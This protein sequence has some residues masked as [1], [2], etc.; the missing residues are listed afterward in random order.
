MVSPNVFITGIFLVTANANSIRSLEASS[1]SQPSKNYGNLVCP[2]KKSENQQW[3][4]C[5]AKSS[6]SQE[7]IEAFKVVAV[8]IYGHLQLGSDI[9]VLKLVDVEIN[10]NV[11]ENILAV[12]SNK[13]DEL[14]SYAAV[15]AQVK[16]YAE[17]IV[18]IQVWINILHHN[19]LINIA[20]Q[21]EIVLYV[22]ILLAFRC[23]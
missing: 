13:P 5:K 14:S 10:V 22:V 11:Y 4:E 18:D 3:S 8:D 23:W 16:L 9:N 1:G 15:L 7:C 19:S 2:N 20:L 21:L 6:Q 12:F 17:A